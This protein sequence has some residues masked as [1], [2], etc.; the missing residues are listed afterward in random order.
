MFLLDPVAAAADND[1]VDDDVDPQLPASFPA[2]GPLVDPSR[3]SPSFLF[4]FARGHPDA[5]KSVTADF[6]VLQHLK[7]TQIAIS[8]PIVHYCLHYSLL[9]IKSTMKLIRNK[10]IKLLL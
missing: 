7:M 9:K 10:Q 5:L 4:R 8:E 6:A 3:L 1:D 2:P